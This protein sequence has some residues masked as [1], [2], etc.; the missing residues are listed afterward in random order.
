MVDGALTMDHGIVYVSLHHYENLSLSK[1]I[2][3]RCLLNVFSSSKCRDL[4]LTE[5]VIE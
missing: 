4:S 1:D 2:L 5:A 3:G